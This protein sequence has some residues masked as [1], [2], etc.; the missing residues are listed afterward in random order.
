MKFGNIT[1]HQRNQA[2][3]AMSNL[4]EVENLKTVLQREQSQVKWLNNEIQRLSGLVPQKMLEDVDL[5]NLESKKRQLEE[6]FEVLKQR[7][8]KKEKSIRIAEN[9]IAATVAEINKLQEE[10]E[11]K[12]EE[13]RE[14]SELMEQAEQLAHENAELAE[15]F[16]QEN[17]QMH[18]VQDNLSR[19]NIE[20]QQIQKYIKENG[21]AITESAQYQDRLVE[22]FGDVDKSN[23]PLKELKSKYEEFTSTTAP[24]QENMSNQ[25]DEITK[26]IEKVKA[27]TC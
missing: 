5:D 18:E 2:L 26:L 13:N 16:K 11:I 10:L 19:A 17:Q 25:L 8:A 12:E 22:I 9:K 21:N 27:L 15:V 3:E 14:A 6:K 20:I 1:G 7:N 4:S 24:L 23:I